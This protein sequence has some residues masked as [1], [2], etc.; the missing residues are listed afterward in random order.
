ML[1]AK[2]RIRKSFSMNN[3]GLVE[4]PE[5]YLCQRVVRPTDCCKK[6][7]NSID[8]QHCDVY[9][10]HYGQ[11][12]IGHSGP[13]FQADPS[14]LPRKGYT[15]TPLSRK[16]SEF[17]S[18]ILWP[19]EVQRTV[20][21]GTAKGKLCKDATIADILDCIRSHVKAPGD[22]GAFNNCQTDVY[23]AANECCLDTGLFVPATVVPPV[24]YFPN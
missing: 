2:F 15:C 22:S 4:P 5:F 3:P 13:V 17:F 16:N 8:C 19:N 9:S 1:E 6:I 18:G 20:R 12:Y 21:N 11:I 23:Y 10:V 24:I 14:P 7:L